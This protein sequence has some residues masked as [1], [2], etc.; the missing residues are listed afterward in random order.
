M[1]VYYEL[2]GR[3]IGSHVVRTLQSVASLGARLL[4]FPSAGPA[5]IAQRIFPQ[6]SPTDACPR[7]PISR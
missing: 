4:S 1:V 7:A 5:P 6:P 3:K 2:A